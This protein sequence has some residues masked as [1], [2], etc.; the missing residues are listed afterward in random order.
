MP[1]GEVKGTFRLIC[2]IIISCFFFF[3][4]DMNYKIKHK[5]ISAGLALLMICGAFFLPVNPPLSERLMLTASAQSSFSVVV[6]NA[7]YPTGERPLGTTFGIKGIISSEKTI[8]KVYGGIYSTNG[9]KVMYH[10]TKPNSNKCDLY[11][12]FDQY[13]IF[14]DL[15][16]GNY[17]YIIMAADNDGNTVT[18]I[19]SSFSVTTK[20][21]LASCTAI[22]GASVPADVLP[23]GCAF[24]VRGKIASTFKMKRVWGGVYNTDGSRT[25]AI[26]DTTTNT[27]FYDLFTNF[28]EHIIFSKLGTGEYYYIIYAT[29]MKG[30]MTKLVCKK[31]RIVTNGSSPSDI[32]VYDASYPTGTL[33]KGNTNG[34][35]IVSGSVYSTYELAELTGG[36]Y[37]ASGYSSSYNNAYT[38]KIPLSGTYYNLSQI[39]GGM[40]FGA[41]PEGNYVFKLTVTDSKGYKKDIINSPFRVRSLNKDSQSPSPLIK[42]I[43]VSAHQNDID[44]KKVKA[45]GIDFAVLRAGVTNMSD[46]RYY[47]DSYFEKN[48]VEAKAAGIKLGVYIYTCAF[49]KGEMKYNIEKL[50]E[51]LK[52]K[53]L[54][55]PVYIDVE[56]D[57]RQPQIGKE[58]LTE[59]LEYACDLIS[60]AGFM[61]GLYSGYNWYKNFIDTDRLTQKGC[62]LW[63]ALWPSDPHNCD[64]SDFCSTWQYGSE[65]NISGISGDTDTNYRYTTIT[66]VPHSIKLT[67]SAGGTISSDKSTARLNERVRITVETDKGYIVKSVKYGDKEA[68]KN[69]DGSYS[70]IMPDANV[71]V[72]AEFGY[73]DSIG[74]ILDGYSLSLEGDI[75]INFYMSLSDG[76]AKSSTAYMRFTMPDGTIKKVLVKDAKTAALNG[77]ICYI[78]KCSTAAKEMSSPIKAQIINGTKSGTVYSCSVRDYADY[79]L[80]NKPESDPSVKLVKAMLNYGAYSQEYFQYGGTPAN[81]GA[82]DTAIINISASTINRPFDTDKCALPSGIVFD[83]ASLSLES[84]TSMTLHFSGLRSV[85]RPVV[86]CPGKTIFSK[87][88]GDK[89]SVTISGINAAELNDDITVNV[90]ESGSTGYITYSPMCFCYNVLKSNTT[91]AELKNVVRALYNYSQAAKEYFK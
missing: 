4:T 30:T 42:G 29:D 88:N 91:K 44:W 10:E 56:A 72:K 3:F 18:A 62:E 73:A 80:K 65:G 85:L 83:G 53:K 78:F 75:S 23:K 61:P 9:S 81:L 22:Y 39:D 50:L 12:T 52:G 77:R 69:S 70:F 25:S 66:T 36:I 55:L 76:T 1:D 71:T 57:D 32:Q 2:V 67:Q 74:A 15:P 47:K 86:S 79:I 21:A 6:T 48:Y 90:T 26:Y 34:S 68:T 64:F 43:D 60:D 28:D 20:G 49:N 51:S 35:F 13:M 14:G 5:L 38:V 11:K 84:E 41:L 89:L 59:I 46:A 24:S 87:I 7:S 37:K 58:G 17:Y 8:A 19:S 40:K 45:S 31:F 16:L 33:A 63:L 82:A 27:D 54:D